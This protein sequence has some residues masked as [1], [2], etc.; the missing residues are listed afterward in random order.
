MDGEHALSHSTPHNTKEN[1]TAN[2][3]V[4]NVTVNAKAGR[5][6]MR[7]EPRLAGTVAPG[8]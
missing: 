1:A 7:L 6:N 4:Q 8:I 5:P 2:N 3:P